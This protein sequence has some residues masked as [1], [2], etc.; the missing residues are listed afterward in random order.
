MA[1]TDSYYSGAYLR[2]YK[3]GY[4]GQ[5]KYKD[6]EGNWRT[7]SKALDAKGKRE[8]LKEL[9]AWREQMEAEAQF[10]LKGYKKAETVDE[11]VAQY[12]DTLEH[13][14]SITTST[15]YGYRKHLKYIAAQFSKTLVNDIDPDIVQAWLNGM[16]NDGYSTST[17]KKTFNLLHATYKDAVARRALPYNPLGAVKAPKVKQQE[18]NALDKEGMQRLV[19]YL[20]IAADTP[21]TLAIRLALV[22]GMREGE[23]CGLR[24]RDVDLKAQT[25]R[26][27]TVIGQTNTTYVKEPKTRG[28]RREIP[29]DAETAALLKK[30]RMAMAEECMEAGIPMTTELYVFGSI[31]GS[32]LKPNRLWRD[33]KAISS[34]LGLVGTEGKPPKFHD[35]RHTFATAA[36]AS[37]ADVKSVSSIM[38][39]ANAA[40]TLNIYASADAEAKRRTMENV[41]KV[42][43][44]TP[45]DAEILQ[46]G[47][48]GTEE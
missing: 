40:M 43:T 2:S 4:R 3:F 41:S 9:E 1:K 27:R 10:T 25:V 29:I 6:S 16:L 14:E 33:W 37:G 23:I 38:G 28:S 5:L 13:S 36:I 15:A 44:E 35:L 22:T 8:A 45:R 20:D 24:W 32:Y 26:V 18:P 34:S 30:R 48:T 17:V 47:K 39:H 7:I 11:F 12:I 21:T 42:I 19:S 46:L 31:D